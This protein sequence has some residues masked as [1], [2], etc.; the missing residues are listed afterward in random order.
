MVYLLTF[1]SY[2]AGSKSVSARPS[3]LDTMTNTALEATAS[4]SANESGLCKT[5][6]SRT[7]K[8]GQIIGLCASIFHT[9]NYVTGYPVACELNLESAQTVFFKV[10]LCNN[11]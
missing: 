6:S 11:R 7:M 5:I 4:S 2:S 10:R 8:F 3:D 1:L 9:K